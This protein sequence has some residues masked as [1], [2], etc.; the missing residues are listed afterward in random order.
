MLIKGSSSLLKNLKWCHVTLSQ[1]SE[2]T[3][4]RMPV[5]T[6]STCSWKNLVF[7]SQILIAYS[8]L[9]FLLVLEV[10]HKCKNSTLV[11]LN[12]IYV[13]EQSCMKT[14]LSG[15]ERRK[16]TLKG[17]NFL[18]QWNC[19][20]IWQDKDFNKYIGLNENLML[21]FG[22]KTHNPLLKPFFSLSLLHLICT[23]L[24]LIEKSLQHWP[25]W[26]LTLCI[27]APKFE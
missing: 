13:S 22:I 7:W 11:D 6:A 10:Q 3:M 2:M 9:L 1:E 21:C 14:R 5:T 26:Q 12:L 4:S 27:M 16:T 24:F 8:L 18:V 17:A 23:K 20:L 25:F 19:I 15:K